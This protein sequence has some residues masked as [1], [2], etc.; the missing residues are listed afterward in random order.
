MWDEI[1]IPIQYGSDYNLAKSIIE[2]TGNEIA[3][4]LKNT[5]SE[6]W[7]KLQEKYKLEDTQTEPLVS[8]L[9]NHN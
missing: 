6:K 8:M 9:A 1:K 2:S 5:S 4:D 7:I 3:G